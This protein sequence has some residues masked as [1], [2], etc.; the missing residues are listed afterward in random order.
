MLVTM[1]PAFAVSQ[2][3]FQPQSYSTPALNAWA[4]VTYVALK[5]RS[6][7]GYWVK[8]VLELAPRNV[9]M[10]RKLAGG[11]WAVTRIIDG[12][13]ASTDGLFPHPST[14]STAAASSR[15]LLVSAIDQVTMAIC[16]GRNL[17]STAASGESP[18]LPPLPRFVHWHRSRKSNEAATLFFGVTCQVRRPPAMG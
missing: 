8:L 12:F 6:R 9:V 7:Y 18:K 4:P 13:A 15:N 14:R 16:C 2:R 5:A 1:L 10:P 11:F 17:K 3:S